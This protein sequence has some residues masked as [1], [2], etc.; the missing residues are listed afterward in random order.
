MLVKKTS[1]N[2]II[3]PQGIIKNFPQTE[4]FEAKVE[5]RLC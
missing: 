5:E 3:L 1:R 2:Q 4:Y